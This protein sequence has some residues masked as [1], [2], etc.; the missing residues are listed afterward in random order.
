MKIVFRLLN[1]KLYA[2]DRQDFSNNLAN[3]LALHIQCR[4]NID[5]PCRKIDKLTALNVQL[6]SISNK[7]PKNSPFF[8]F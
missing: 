7:R 2:T 1:T 4:Q 6:M 8:C 3:N 5:H